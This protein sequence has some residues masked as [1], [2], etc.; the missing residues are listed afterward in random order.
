MR[1]PRQLRP[2]RRQ[3][4]GGGQGGGQDQDEEPHHRQADRAEAGEVARGAVLT[5]GVAGDSPWNILE[6]IIILRS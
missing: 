1:D 2:L 3:E 6:I 4:A 5:E